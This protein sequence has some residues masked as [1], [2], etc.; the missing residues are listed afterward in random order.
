M[1]VDMCS[2]ANNSQKSIS[3]WLPDKRKT[4]VESCICARNANNIQQ[5]HPELVRLVGTV[6]DEDRTESIAQ[7]NRF[8]MGKEQCRD[9]S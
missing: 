5:R 1:N 2:S 9:R 4:S 7:F 8:G 3:N 6:H